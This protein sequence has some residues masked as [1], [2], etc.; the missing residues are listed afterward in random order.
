LGS[1]INEGD[2]FGMK[3]VVK[4]GDE[5]SPPLIIEHFSRGI[6]IEHLSKRPVVIKH[7][8]IGS[9]LGSPQAGKL[10]ME[11]VVFKNT[12]TLNPQQKVWARQF[13]SEIP[14][15]RILNN[16]ADLWLLGIK[17]ELTGTVI[18]TTNCGKTELLGGLIYPVKGFSSKEAAFIAEDANQSLIFGASAYNTSYMY[19]VM[20]REKQNGITKELK[21]GGEIRYIMPLFV[22]YNPACPGTA[23]TE[24][25]TVKTPVSYRINAGGPP[26]INSIG[27]FEADAHYSTGIA[28][29]SSKPIAGTTEDAI[30]QSERYASANNANLSYAFPVS[31]GQYKVVLHFAELYHTLIGKRIF[32]VAI[33]DT[34]VLDN[35]DMVKAVGALTADVKVFT[36]NVT[37]GTLN[38][39]FIGLTS[40]G[41]IERP[42]VSAI[43]IIDMAPAS[44]PSETAASRLE[45]KAAKAEAP[46][47]QNDFDLFPNPAVDNLNV[48]NNGL[49]DLTADVEIKNLAG[50]TVFKAGRVVFTA[51]GIQNFSKLESLSSGVYIL[52]ITGD[53][54]MFTK[55]FILKK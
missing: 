5:N 17:T 9:Y 1:V 54:L 44:L 45:V 49:T 12:L 47:I 20:V 19:P 23:A 39:D 51:G 40:E 18:K 11:D 22:G 35:Y 46:D 4:D 42:K 3:L 27:T 50:Q 25:A 14:S 31:S 10:F 7:S 52:Y 32:D 16:G 29:T 21:Y 34:K 38:I 43:E 6:S 53:N 2:Q 30:Y 36:A 48:R 15:T 24:A 37:D 41:A 13:N 33:E 8:H 26:V 55:K 28:K